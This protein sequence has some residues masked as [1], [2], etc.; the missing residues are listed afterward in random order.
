MTD[1]LPLW[2]VLVSEFKFTVFVGGVCLRCADSVVVDRD[3]G[4]GKWRPRLRAVDATAVA[5]RRRRPKG[6]GP[7]VILELFE[8]C[9]RTAVV[10]R[11]VDHNMDRANEQTSGANG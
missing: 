11:V 7:V 3:G 8:V 1:P 9:R 5:A 4:T 2:V 6:A 10:V